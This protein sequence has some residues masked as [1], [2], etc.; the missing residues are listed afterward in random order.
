MHS[1]T[2]ALGCSGADFIIPCCWQG[3]LLLDIL[4]K[5]ID[6]SDIAMPLTTRPR[7]PRVYSMKRNKHLCLRV[8]ENNQGLVIGLADTFSS[9][10][11]IATYPGVHE[12]SGFERY[13]CTNQALDRRGKL[14]LVLHLANR[15]QLTDE[16][17]GTLVNPSLSEVRLGRVRWVL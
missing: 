12:C 6:S 14:H 8:K 1:Q 5:T 4:N 16:S 17:I 7:L 9:S 11:V 13:L 10:T 2:V 15:K 3:L